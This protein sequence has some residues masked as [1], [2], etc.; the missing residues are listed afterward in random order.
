[1]K[2]TL[3]VGVL[4][5]VVLLA[6]VFLLCWNHHEQ[7]VGGAHTAAERYSLRHQQSF[8]GQLQAEAQSHIQQGV[9]ELRLKKAITLLRNQHLDDE[10]VFVWSQVVPDKAEGATLRLLFV[11]E[12]CRVRTIMFMPDQPDGTW[13]GGERG[14]N[15]L[16]FPFYPGRARDGFYNVRH[17][18][19]VS[20]Q[21]SDVVE[22]P[23]AGWRV[24]HVPEGFFERLVLGRGQFML[25]DV[26][27]QV[28][29]RLH[30][31]GAPER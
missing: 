13:D 19:S 31:A 16:Y 25:V 27:G 15:Y 7:G 12:C 5:G 28:L 1:M 21:G 17:Y 18:L 24:L 10:V 20:E 23:D 8:A 11:D 4:L 6:G 2:V 30:V 26:N 14:L 22:D 3:V 9:S 29:D